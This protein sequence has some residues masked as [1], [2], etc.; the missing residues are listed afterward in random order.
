MKEHE[1]SCNICTKCYLGRRCERLKKNNKEYKK[2]VD[3]EGVWPVNDKTYNRL[4]QIEKEN[5]CPEFNS[6]YIT[7]PMCV[8]EVKTE[9]IKYEKPLG[10]EKGC[11]VAV[12]PCGDEYKKK[13][14]LGILIADMP[15]AIIS[16][17][18]KKTEILENSIMTN[19]GIYV[20]ELKEII[21]GDSSWWHE[22]ASEEELREITDDDIN[23][24]W[25]VK[26]LKGE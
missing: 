22:I 3:E 2:L 12:R 20:P 11:L 21:F 10:H 24:T 15:R 6:I 14:Y 18:D 16:R 17:F 25:Y 1:N 5:I 13:T 8:H 23:N 7:Y 9:E 19:P 4:S 26:L